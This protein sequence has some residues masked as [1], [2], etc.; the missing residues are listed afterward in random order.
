MFDCYIKQCPLNVKLEGSGRY[1]SSA[2]IDN[3]DCR[4][5]RMETAKGIIT[6]TD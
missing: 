6:H 2:S 1:L 4:K 5:N 3:S